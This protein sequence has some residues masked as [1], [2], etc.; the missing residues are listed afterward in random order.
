M[1]KGKQPSK[2]FFIVYA[3]T[4]ARSWIRISAYDREFRLG[5][6]A[7]N[8]ASRT[9]HISGLQHRLHDDKHC[10]TAWYDLHFPPG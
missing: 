4:L 3:A 2:G 9:G 1:G 10:I 6:P 7:H 5:V 8:L